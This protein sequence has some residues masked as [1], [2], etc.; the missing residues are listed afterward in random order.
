MS[1]P[2]IESLKTFLRQIHP[3]EDA[4]LTEYVSR[5]NIHSE[6]RKV[7]LTPAGK[8][9]RYLYFVTEGV[10]KSYYLNEGKEHVIAFTYP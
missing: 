5:W 4:I 8:T 6:P 1:D 2:T 9:E 7:L 10:Q 3:V